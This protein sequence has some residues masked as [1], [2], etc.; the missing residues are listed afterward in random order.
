[1]R[2]LIGCVPYVYSLVFII[3]SQNSKA[4]RKADNPPSPL[5]DMEDEEYMLHLYILNVG[6]DLL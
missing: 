3:C 4:K 2:A 1:M 6:H 5:T